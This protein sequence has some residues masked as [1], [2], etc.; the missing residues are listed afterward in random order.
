M[1]RTCS[2]CQHIKRAEIDHRLAAGEPGN[3]IAQDYGINP[4]SLHRHRT[5]CLGLASANAIKKQATRG[6]AALACLPSR[7]QLGSAYAELKDRIDRIASQA[8]GEGSLK[9]ALS[10][11]N[12]VRPFKFTFRNLRIGVAVAAPRRPRFVPL[13]WGIPN[14]FSKSPPS[15]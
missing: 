8:E 13:G 10:G 2:T 3:Q 9:V 11:L 12:S 7:H 4:S 14:L 5:N 6:S 15:R 1:S